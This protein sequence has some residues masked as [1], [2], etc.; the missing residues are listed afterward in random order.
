VPRYAI[1]QIVG[2]SEPI[3]RCRTLASRFARSDGTVLI[4]GESGSG[5]ELFAQGIHNASRRRRHAFVAVNCAAF[6][7]SLL[8]SELF[9]YEEGAFT[10]S[11]RGGKPGLF[12][13]A[14][15]GTLFLDEIGEMPIALQTRLLRVLQEKEVWRLGATE[16]TLV[17]V[18]VI[19]ATHRNLL[20]RIARGQFRQDLYYRLNIL[21]LE[22]PPLRHRK[23]DIPALAGHL[24]AR[25][26]GR[27]GAAPG[28]DVLESLLPYLAAHDWPGNVREL[29]NVI[30][31]MALF[32]SGGEDVRSFVSGGW[33]EAFPELTRSR[34]AAEEADSSLRSLNHSHDLAYVRQVLEE[35]AGDRR[36]ACRK[37][38]ISR[39]TLWRKLKAGGM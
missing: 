9:G 14:H 2:E 31:R 12:E 18:R 4:L 19:A 24:W 34:P 30:E 20:E 29:E 32:C 3:A 28:R 1:D 10:G 6:P 15:T 5:K 35:C 22:V 33:R 13:I 37:L 27:T 16:P 21:T 17:D 8:E 23:E 38:G 7:E 25:A 39:T 11:R 36:A 26:A